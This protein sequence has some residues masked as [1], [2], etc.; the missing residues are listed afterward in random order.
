LT[1]YNHNLD[2][3]RRHYPSIVS[4]RSYDE[5]LHTLRSVQK[6]GIAVCCGG[7]LGTGETEEDR[8]MLLVELAQLDPPPESEPI[9]CLVAIAG[10]P[11]RAGSTFPPTT[12]WATPVWR[13]GGV[14]TLM[15]PSGDSRPPLAR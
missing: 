9:N 12:I 10:Q 2:T 7:I 6:A 13:A 8:L 15:A 1:A 5:R 3:S 4:T 14:S 11:R